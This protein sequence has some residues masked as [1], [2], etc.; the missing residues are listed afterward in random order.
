MNDDL[1]LEFIADTEA[2]LVDV[3]RAESGARLLDQARRVFATINGTCGFLGLRR[4]G[5]LTE[6]AVQTLTLIGRPGGATPGAVNLA[7]DIL[8]SVK[9]QLAFL[10]HNRAEMAG[11]DEPLIVRMQSY[12]RNATVAA[13]GLVF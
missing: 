3:T 11:S 1:I 12:V 9:V 6:A 10:E 2:S 4:L 7:L 8:A 5:G 13:Q